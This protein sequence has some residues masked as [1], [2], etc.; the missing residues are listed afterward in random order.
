VIPVALIQ[1]NRIRMAQ[2]MQDD[3]QA[4]ANVEPFSGKEGTMRPKSMKRYLGRLGIAAAVALGGILAWDAAVAGV[5][6]TRHNL[7]SSAGPAGRNQVSDTDEICVF[8]HTPH[9]ADVSNPAPLWN[10]RLA[11]GASYTT[12]ASINSSTMNAEFASDGV[13]GTSVGSVSLACLSCHDGTQAMDNIINAPGS[14]G[15]TA[16]GGGTNGLAYNWG[17]SP[18]IDAGGFG[19]LTGVANLGSDLSNDHPIGIQYCG[20][21]PNNASPGAA[22]NDTDFVAPTSATIGGALAFWVDTGGA[23]RQ[24]TDMILYNRT[25]TAGAGPSVECASCHDPHSE[26]TTFLRIA[27]TG[28]AVCL[29][30]HVK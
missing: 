9:G 14:G 29:A 12:Y 3:G 6:N 16:G 8:C 11:T 24:K 18:R 15:L 17:T 25:F 22:C 4:C 13:G 5:A 30:C 1:I 21:G 2:M 19:L 28:S 23:G 7:G 10:K 20:G 26:N 27:N